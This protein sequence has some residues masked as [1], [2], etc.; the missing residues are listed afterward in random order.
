[1]HPLP[2][3]HQH[4]HALR[5][6]FIGSRVCGVW[7]LAPLVCCRLRIAPQYVL[8]VVDTEIDG[9]HDLGNAGPETDDGLFSWSAHV[10][11][12]REGDPTWGDDARGKG[13]IGAINYV[14]AQSLHAAAS[15]SSWPTGLQATA[16]QNAR[17]C[18]VSLCVRVYACVL[19][20]VCG[21]NSS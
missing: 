14:N 11:D 4:L 6:S 2:H 19:W 16:A 8:L 20:D 5:P 7:R 15:M 1:M 9:T 12:W 10:Q 18:S 3:C 17:A 13:L 21:Y